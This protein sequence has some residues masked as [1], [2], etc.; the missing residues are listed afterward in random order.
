MR[1]VRVIT[2]VAVSVVATVAAVV[3]YAHMQQV[4]ARVGEGWRSYLIPLSIDGSV[5][6]ASMVL[7]TR[8]HHGQPPSVLAWGALG[9]GVIMS[10]GANMA[11]AQPGLTALLVAGWPAVAFAATVELLLQQRR[12]EPTTSGA[13]SDSTQPAPTP[14]VRTTTHDESAGAVPPVMPTPASA[15]TPPKTPTLT[16]L[17]PPRP[18]TAPPVTRVDADLVARVQR[19]VAQRPL[20]RRA[21]AKQL[22]VS[23]HA[24]RQALTHL[25]YRKEQA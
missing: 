18:T 6:A 19:L 5:T 12:A 9:A 1:T 23:E 21:L 10:V 20:G 2:V 14:T 7:L 4:G 25:R 13:H 3:S 17:H 11:D 22:G 16:L 24:V 8:R 15:P